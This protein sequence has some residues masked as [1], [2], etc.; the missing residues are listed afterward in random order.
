MGRLEMKTATAG[1]ARAAG[2]LALSLS[3]VGVS[4]SEETPEALRQN[5]DSGSGESARACYQLA[6]RYGD[7]RGIAKDAERAAALLLKACDARLAQACFTACLSEISSRHTCSILGNSGPEP[8]QSV[9]AFLASRDTEQRRQML[10]SSR[11]LGFLWWIIEEEAY[12]EIASLPEWPSLRDPNDWV[13]SAAITAIKDEAVLADV[14]R[15][16]PEDHVLELVAR[17]TM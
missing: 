1:L 3:L 16:R 10:S 4:G 2:S 14:I 9:R 8:W 17:K 13:Y 11:N 5:C 7:G 15:Q 12:D 6:L